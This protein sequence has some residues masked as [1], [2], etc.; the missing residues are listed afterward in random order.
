MLR[1]VQPGPASSGNNATSSTS[2]AAVIAM[3]PVGQPVLKGKY[4]VGS[5]G[6]DVR[7]A[8]QGF[9]D[10]QNLAEVVSTLRSTLSSKIAPQGS[11]SQ[12]ASAI[13]QHVIPALVATLRKYMQQSD[14]ADAAANSGANSAAAAIGDASSSAGVHATTAPASS[15]TSVP[16]ELAFDCLWCL[17]NLGAGDNA[18]TRLLLKHGVAELAVNAI[19]TSDRD[20]IVECAIWVLGNVAGDGHVSREAVRKAGGGEAITVRAACELGKLG[21]F[22]FGATFKDAVKA[23]SQAAAAAEAGTTGE[24]QSDSLDACASNDIAD[25]D[26]DSDDDGDDDADGTSSKGAGSRRSTEKGKSVKS[27][28]KSAS[29]ATWASAN[30]SGSGDNCAGASNTRRLKYTSPIL[31]ISTWAL[32]NLCEGDGLN[33]S[34][35]GADD[36]AAR[37]GGDGKHGAA[38][39]QARPG[40]TMGCLLAV[41]NACLDCPDQEVLAHA[42]RALSHVADGP[43]EN[44]HDLLCSLQAHTPPVQVKSVVPSAASSGSDLKALPSSASSIWPSTAASSSSSSLRHSSSCDPAVLGRWECMECGPAADASEATSPFPL[45]TPASLQERYAASEQ[46][47]AKAPLASFAF[48]SPRGAPVLPSTASKLVKLLRHES[49]RVIK[50]ALRCAGNIVCSEVNDDDDIDAAI[51]EPDYTQAMVQL[52]LVP[53]LRKLM[54]TVTSRELLKEACWTMSNVAAGTKEQIQAVLD[55]GCLARTV[56]LCSDPSTDNGVRTEALWILLNSTSCG[57]ESQI[58]IL[59][60][61]GVV[62]VLCTMLSDPAMSSMA[63]EG[64]EKVIHT[65]ERIAMSAASLPSQSVGSTSSGS[66]G[67]GGKGAGGSMSSPAASLSGGKGNPAP[68]FLP[69]T[70][71]ADVIAKLASKTSS[72]GKSGAGGATTSVNLVSA[73][74]SAITGAFES[75]AVV[76][77]SGAGAAASAAAAATN[78]IEAGVLA[79]AR[80]LLD[81]FRAEF[82]NSGSSSGGGGRNHGGMGGSGGV[83]HRSGPDGGVVA[84][85]GRGDSAMRRVN[86]LWSDHF[87]TCG[88]CRRTWARTSSQTHYCDECRCDVCSECDCKKFHLSYQLELLESSS[89]GTSSGATNAGGSGTSKEGKGKAGKSKGKDSKGAAAAT[90]KAAAPAVVQP[91]QRPPSTAS[92]GSTDPSGTTAGKGRSN[93]GSASPSDAD[94]VPG[95]SAAQSAASASVN[96]ASS[97]IPVSKTA[98]KT[99]RRA[100]QATFGASSTAAVS[101]PAAPA[102]VAAAKQ[103]STASAPTSSSSNSKG[104]AAAAAAKPGKPQKESTAAASIPAATPSLASS[105]AAA[106]SAA[107][108]ALSANAAAAAQVALLESQA[109]NASSSEEWQ[110]VGGSGKQGGSSSTAASKGGAEKDASS[111]SSSSGKAKTV[112]AASTAY[113]SPAQPLRGTAPHKPPASNAAAV[114]PTKAAA[115]HSAASTLAQQTSNRKPAAASSATV[116]SPAAALGAGAAGP[117]ASPSA[118]GAARTTLPVPSTA[119]KPT[120]AQVAKGAGAASGHSA[121]SSPASGGAASAASAT[122]PSSSPWGKKPAS[123]AATMS[124]TGSGSVTAGTASAG[125]GAGLLPIVQATSQFPT[126]QQAVSSP[127]QGSG[128]VV[129]VAAPSSSSTVSAAS[130][131]SGSAST[132]VNA[133]PSAN[134]QQPKSWKNIVS[135]KQQ[136]QQQAGATASAVQHQQHPNAP[137]GGPDRK[138]SHSSAG[139]RSTPS[140]SAPGSPLLKPGAGQHAAHPHPGSAA[141]GIAIGDASQASHEAAAGGASA[142]RGPLPTTVRPPMP[143]VSAGGAGGSV[144]DAM[145]SIDLGLPHLPPSSSAAAMAGMH[146]PSLLGLSGGNVMGSMPGMMM[147]PPLPGAPPLPPMPPGNSSGSGYYQQHHQSQIQPPLPGSSP[148]ASTGIGYN[149]LQARASF[150]AS[151][152]GQQ[153]SMMMMGHG[154]GHH[155]NNAQL[156][157]YPGSGSLGMMQGGGGGGIPGMSLGQPSITGGPS[158][159]NPLFSMLQQQ[160]PQPLPGAPP[161]PPMSSPG[162]SGMQSMPVPASPLLS[163]MGLGMGVN[164]GGIGAGSV[165]KPG[166]TL[167]EGV[168]IPA[169]VQQQQAQQ[170]QQLQMQFQMHMQQVLAAAAQQAAHAAASAAARARANSMAARDGQQSKASSDADDSN[171]ENKP[172]SAADGGSAGTA[173]TATDSSSAAPNS[174][175]ASSAANSNANT[176][177]D[178]QNPLGVSQE[179]FAAMLAAAMQSAAAASNN[180]G[181]SSSNGMGVGNNGMSGP[182]GSAPP[183]PGQPP[184]PPGPP[185]DDPYYHTNAAAR[186]RA[187]SGSAGNDGHWRNDGPP[188]RDYT[189]INSSMNTNNL[190]DA[191]DSQHGG[192]GAG[193]M[194]MMMNANDVSFAGSTMSGGGGGQGDEYT[195][196]SGGQFSN[197]RPGQG[198]GQGTRS[199][200]NSMHSHYSSSNANRGPV[201]SFDDTYR[202]RSGSRYH[203]GQGGGGGGQQYGAPAP[204]ALTLDAFIRSATPGAKDKDDGSADQTDGDDAGTSSRRHDN[205]GDDE[206]DDGS[207]DADAGGDG[208]HASGGS[209]QQQHHHAIDPAVAKAEAEAMTL[210]MLAE[211]MQSMHMVATQ[212]AQAL[213]MQAAAAAAARQFPGGQPPLPGQSPTMRPAGSGHMGSPLISGAPS[214][215][216]MPPTSFASLQAFD[217]SGIGL[218][219]G[220]P[221]LPGSGNHGGMSGYHG[222]LGAAASSPPAASSVSFLRA[223]SPISIGSASQQESMGRGGGLGGLPNSGAAPS[224]LLSMLSQQSPG[225]QPMSMQQQHPQQQYAVSAANRDRSGSF[226]SMPG[227]V[228]VTSAAPSPI[229]PSFGGIPGGGNPSIPSSSSTSFS[230]LSFG[231][232]SSLMGSSGL[233]SSSASNGSASMWSAGL[234]A[235]TVGNNGN[236]SG[237][238]SRSP[239]S[240]PQ[241]G[242][243]MDA[244]GL[245]SGSLMDFGTLDLPPPSVTMMSATAPLPS[246][247]GAGGSMTMQ[248][249]KPMGDGNNGSVRKGSSVRADVFRKFSM[250]NDDNNADVNDGGGDDIG[251]D[252]LSSGLSPNF[253]HLS[254]SSTSMLT[255]GLLELSS[256][257]T[258]SPSTAIAAGAHALGL[259]GLDLDF[260]SS[261]ASALGAHATSA[262]HAT[263]AGAAARSRKHSFT[264]G[265]TLG[266]SSGAAVAAP[267]MHHVTSIDQLV[268]DGESDD[269]LKSVMALTS[270]PE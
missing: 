38:A 157:P 22:P 106:A 222:G 94:D 128:A 159:G 173:S 214:S 195:A 257:T 184:L 143:P 4:G 109:A 30:S 42:C 241:L 70:A 3:T 136:Q 25:D 149:A 218:D 93:N 82:L 51:T 60:K 37:R 127:P 249:G 209:G 238:P 260:T 251:I 174:G 246:S 141:S 40:P 170:Q 225:L 113:A 67:K 230:H 232:G 154:G 88:L 212:Q 240:S 189:S 101:T 252:N 124:G 112:G 96:D 268:V 26:A 139:N 164:V 179:A 217:N 263:E 186:S 56:Q 167:M 119:P 248:T 202:P 27:E 1:R 102:A 12:V 65:Y 168:H 11:L 265:A 71:A 172:S 52:G 229:H 85:P 50:P 137:G 213:Q 15:S 8:I 36:G 188:Q 35:D 134:P 147:Q 261:L 117:G 233:G 34:D 55:S 196:T 254:S 244:M 236:N 243:G 206:T 123:A 194:S 177:S 226:L 92:A 62:K 234:P 203:S 258:S 91:A 99:V 74:A 97:F 247:A 256:E 18:V 200:I 120:A 199:R 269:L 59:V 144:A 48:A 190:D 41:L 191:I 125:A 111:S 259:I 90:T 135:G 46:Y 242:G 133:A 53:Q 6:E 187:M 24:A 148:M 103:H 142:W 121:V 114:T 10:A 150:D 83:D 80:T 132:A 245:D 156:P 14:T 198:Q 211:R 207:A 169:A 64:L 235:P 138:M 17:I 32:A 7:L 266:N 9:V 118:V 108:A 221:P 270:M 68:S 178:A 29:S 5:I 19:R 185:R 262:K 57:T 197:R 69:P 110:P 145:G 253:M 45:A 49:T 205:E 66:K 192:G 181:G 155:G 153:Q 2:P 228:V 95:S 231:I 163:G 152:R 151:S 182:A 224:T 239:F 216:M 219:S 129:G 61:A 84:G 204:R 87:V 44:I 76:A 122:A 73:L 130:T 58:E 175:T 81:T 208:Q 220:L 16:D 165:L 210:A 77:S 162:S 126:L 171:S 98:P 116:A 158:A 140:S 146:S 131:N 63:L 115:A 237:V 160:H 180:N 20:N 54:E 176:S 215:M 72:G 255:S 193:N 86:K 264:D 43:P 78:G 75:I 227:G 201:G 89:S 166:V 104:T 47:S 39:N 107:S 105:A 223:S 267:S 21:Y 161:L 28:A 250:G 183:L 23:A 100:L 13:D 79:D 33:G 31:K